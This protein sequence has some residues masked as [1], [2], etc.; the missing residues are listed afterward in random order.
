MIKIWRNFYFSSRSSLDP[1]DIFSSIQFEQVYLK[2]YSNITPFKDLLTV[3]S[4]L[5]FRTQDLILSYTLSNWFHETSLSSF[6]K[7]KV[8]WK[9]IK[10]WDVKPQ[11]IH[12]NQIVDLWDETLELL[13]RD[14]AIAVGV[15]QFESLKEEGRK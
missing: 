11:N 10:S 12:F 9:Y 15:K 7:I 13:C 2:K 8:L 4:V 1:C 14:E 3:E 6:F 5:F